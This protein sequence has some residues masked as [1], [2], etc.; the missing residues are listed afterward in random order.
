[1]TEENNQQQQQQFDI[2]R[3]YLKDLSF[4]VPDAP[5]V[6]LQDEEPNVSLDIDV[7]NQQVEDQLYEVELHL[8]VSATTTEQKSIFLVEVKY[9]GIFALSGFEG[10]TLNGMLGSFCPSIIFP[11]AREVISDVVTKGSFPQLVL[12]P[13]NF[14]ALY[15]QRQQAAEES[16][17]QGDKKH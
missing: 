8:T 3:L 15:Q 10:E 7:N 6:F 2:Q 12:S 17:Q 14:D 9:A 1:M 4:E 13:I 11:Y 5:Q 16:A